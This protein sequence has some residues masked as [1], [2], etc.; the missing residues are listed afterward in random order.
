MIHSISVLPDFI[1]QMSNYSL[2]V[3]LMLDPIHLLSGHLISVYTREAPIVKHADMNVSNK[4]H[5]RDIKTAPTHK[6]LKYP[7]N[8]CHN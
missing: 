1:L 4:A 6:I 8:F 7:W 2:T 5:S 3:Y